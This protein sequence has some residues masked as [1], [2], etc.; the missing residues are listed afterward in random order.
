M[1]IDLLLKRFDLGLAQKSLLSLNL[2]H[3][4]MNLLGHLIEIY[5]DSL[6]LVVRICIYLNLQIPLFDGIHSVCQAAHVTVKKLTAS[7]H[8]CQADS[9]RQK[10]NCKK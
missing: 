1:R 4:L 5:Y 10:Q 7:I 6:N 9:Q 3:Q 2:S 8:H